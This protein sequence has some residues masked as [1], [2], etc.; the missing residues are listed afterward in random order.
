MFSFLIT[1]NHEVIRVYPALSRLQCPLG[2]VSSREESLFEHWGWQNSSPE[3]VAEE[4]GFPLVVEWRLPLGPRAH[5]PFSATGP[6]PVSDGLAGSS[7]QARKEASG[8]L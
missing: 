3:T 8:I 7:F 2:C 1:C 6:F 5:P 4:P